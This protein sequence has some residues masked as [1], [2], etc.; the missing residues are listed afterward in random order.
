MNAMI[1][2][3]LDT[4]DLLI[5]DNAGR[6]T[7]PTTT[8]PAAGGA[9]T[10]GPASTAVVAA[11]PA[12]PTVLTATAASRCRGAAFALR[13]A[14]ESAVV[15]R[16]MSHTPGGGRTDITLIPGAPRCGPWD[17]RRSRRASLCCRGLP[18][19]PG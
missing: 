11:V 10:A 8:G 14:L 2:Q 5:R 12:P 1:R 17:W 13:A 15:A 9:G 18:E 6:A 4:A 3:L 16:L 7:R 19:R